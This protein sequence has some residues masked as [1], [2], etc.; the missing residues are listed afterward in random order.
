M[1]AI[2]IDGTGTSR[3]EIAMPDFVGIFRQLDPLE[4]GFTVVIEQA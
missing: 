1:N 2:G 3:G 4:L